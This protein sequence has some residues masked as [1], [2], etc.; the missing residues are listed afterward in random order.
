ML[1]EVDI[2]VFDVLS[3]IETSDLQEELNKRSGAIRNYD[4]ALAGVYYALCEGDL[5]R[6]IKLMNPVLLEAIG[7]EV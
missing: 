7:R 2:D 5:E 1:V 4:S 3:D 6:T